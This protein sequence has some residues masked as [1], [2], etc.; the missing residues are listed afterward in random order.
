MSLLHGLLNIAEVTL[1]VRIKSN[2][3]VIY[4]LRYYCIIFMSY[5]LF[6]LFIFR[7]V[8][9][10]GY[11]FIQFIIEECFSILDASATMISMR[12][13]Q[14]FTTSLYDKTSQDYVTLQ[15]KVTKMVSKLM[16]KLFLESFI[17]I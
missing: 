8:F 14:P 15:N 9:N 3:N 2:D 6:L 13:V 12:I 5:L 16:V 7:F 11:Y 17:V 10:V 1:M 4:Y